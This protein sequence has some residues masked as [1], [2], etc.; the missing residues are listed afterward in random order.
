M[1]MRL[2]PL[3]RLGP[4]AR[5]SLGLMSLIVSL[6]LAFDLFFG[7]LPTRFDTQREVRNA[8]AGALG[9]H[10]A[11]L[12]EQGD[13]DAIERTFAKTLEREKSVVSLALR[14]GDGRAAVQTAEH[15]QRWSA[16]PAGQSTINHV[17]VPL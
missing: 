4:I 9:V 1:A 10:A 16:P 8:L 2:L 7:V 12:L 3:P 11:T 17:R 6:V 5:L 13:R 14:R 15:E